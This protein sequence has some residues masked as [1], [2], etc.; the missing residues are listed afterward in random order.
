MAARHEAAAGAALVALAAWE[1]AKTYHQFAPSLTELRRVDRDDVDARQRLL[2]ADLTVGGLAVLVGALAS[3]LTE[4]WI[5]LAMA[6][7]AFAWIAGLS[8]LVQGSLTP[9]EIP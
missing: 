7:V 9:E 5:P 6:V 4:S 3:W 1:M 8:H 2:D